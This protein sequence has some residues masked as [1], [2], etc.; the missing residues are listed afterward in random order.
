MPSSSP[1]A[2]ST[3][4]R[5]SRSGATRT[6]PA[7]SISSD[8]AIDLTLSDSEESDDDDLDIVSHAIFVDGRRFECRPAEP[9]AS[10][11]PAIRKSNLDDV[12]KVEAQRPAHNVTPLV[13][14]ID[15][16]KSEDVDVVKSEG[17]AND[18]VREK[19]GN[20]RVKEEDEAKPKTED[21]EERPLRRGR[22]RHA[23][24]TPASPTPH[25]KRDSSAKPELSE[26]LVDGKKLK[27]YKKAKELY[28]RCPNQP[29]TQEML[30]VGFNILEPEALLHHEKFRQYCGFGDDV[31][32]LRAMPLFHREHLKGSNCGTK[33]VD[34]GFTT[35]RLCTNAVNNIGLH[36]AGEPFTFMT[37][38]KIW[39]DRLQRFA[40]YFQPEEERL[41]AEQAQL[42]DMY[43]QRYP[44]L[45]AVTLGDAV[46]KLKWK[47]GGIS[48]TLFMEYLEMDTG[49]SLF[50]FEKC[51]M[52]KAKT[53]NI[54]TCTSEQAQRDR[55]EK[56][57]KD[58]DD[59]LQFVL[60]LMSWYDPNT[61]ENDAAEAERAR[62][63]FGRP[64]AE[65]LAAQA[66]AEKEKKEKKREKAQV[67]GEKAKKEKRKAKGKAA[68][69]KAK[70]QRID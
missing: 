9:T 60:H 23:A 32:K 48:S 22:S 24:P 21:A 35:T 39:K 25:L 7:T 27:D 34:T 59:S 6:S 69:G 42:I 13:A 63:P 44:E 43:R 51:Y 46:Q 56:A 49:Y 52:D 65:E 53:V 55:I 70:K 8:K 14:K 66:L 54:R 40:L 58:N 18:M 2:S 68:G 47:S 41:S 4:T 50:V 30:D 45:S 1:S 3:S 64:Y 33:R 17:Q 36:Q 12:P 37:D 62:Q 20:S 15:E 26:E 5:S 38:G 11:T 61:A 67:E 10:K 28:E 19:D 16:V 29:Y 31:D 57:L